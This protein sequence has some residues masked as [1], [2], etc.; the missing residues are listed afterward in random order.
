[1]LVPVWHHLMDK[2]KQRIARHPQL[3]EQPLSELLS[4][5]LRAALAE[6]DPKAMW[7]CV[8]GNQ[9]PCIFFGGVWKYCNFIAGFFCKGSFF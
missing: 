9:H 4:P 7:K 3:A 2:E 5:E 6:K 8:E 1:M